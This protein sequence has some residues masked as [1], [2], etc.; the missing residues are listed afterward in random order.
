MIEHEI[1]G[2]GPTT[3]LLVHGSPG[4]S[5]TWRG[6]AEKLA[7]S[8]RLLLPTLPGHGKQPADGPTT[9]SALAEAVAAIVPAEPVTI[10]AH[11]FG[12]NVS[13]RLAMRMPERVTRMMLLEPVTLRALDLVGDAATYEGGKH[14]FESYL[15]AADA[16]TP[17]AISA[18]VDFWFGP[19]TFAAM[20]ERM[21]QGLNA[22]TRVNTR[23]VRAT[24]ADDF[25]AADLAALGMPIR[26]VIGER[27]PS[28]NKQIS[29]AIAK[30][31]PR[32]EIVSLPGGTHAMPQT[33][34]AELARMIEDFAS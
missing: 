29:A 27:S 24:F 2:D 4:N 20:P 21:R 11:S 7:P 17:D 31:A 1:V 19:G 25:S 5:Q 8:F 18:M 33:H 28:T 9:V 6:I 10:V 32:A 23:D 3:L 14:H 22:G 15:A 16:K 13:L 30:L 26:L 12:A 34:V